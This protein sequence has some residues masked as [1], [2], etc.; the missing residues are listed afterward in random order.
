MPVP[1]PHG[2]PVP[3]TTASR[4]AW[5]ATPAGRTLLD[6]EL[7]CV[8]AALGERPGQ[9]WLWLAPAAAGGDTPPGQGLRLQDTADG[10]TGSLR[11]RLPLPLANES[12]A[13]VVV[14]HLAGDGDRAS[15]LIEEC[16]RVLVPGGR[17]TL[18]SLNPLSAWRWRWAADGPGSSEPM[19][20]RRRM[21]AAGLVPEAVSEG[22]GPRWGLVPDPSLQ[23]GP[24]V[25]AAW[26]LR[27]EKRVSP[28]TPV[29]T[30][31]PLRIGGE[32]PAA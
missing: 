5:F 14:Q 7:P 25:R 30:R 26:L 10:W 28:L 15:M 12:V 20:W 22:V 4:D 19:P 11:C 17:L 23:H 8:H 31:Q 2:Q 18:L 9:P 21:R 29:R 3:P 27:A 32:V 16:A 1:S 6:S 24:G 13:T